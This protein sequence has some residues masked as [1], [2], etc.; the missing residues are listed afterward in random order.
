MCPS[1]S[2]VVLP[3]SDIWRSI[4]EDDTVD[5]EESE[6]ATVEYPRP[7]IRQP[8]LQVILNLNLSSPFT[9]H[10]SRCGTKPQVHQAMY[11]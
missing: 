2:F 9:V 3:S 11:L 7:K 4:L 1:S 8:G 5:S 10:F 6:R